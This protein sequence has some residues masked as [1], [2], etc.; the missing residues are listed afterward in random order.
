MYPIESK[1]L[2][3]YKQNYRQVATITMETDTET[4]TITEADIK[5]GGLIFNR[6]SASGERIELGSVIAGELTLKLNNIDGKFNSVQFEGAELYVTIGIKKWDAHAWELPVL[7]TMPLGYFTVDRTPRMLETIEITALDRMVQFDKYVD[8]T[9]ITLPTT[10][11][12]LISHCATACNVPLN[13]VISELP[14]Y[15]Y[16]IKSL[17]DSAELTYRQLVSW[18]AGITGNCAYIDREGRLC[19]GWYEEKD[20]TLTPAE[21]YNSDLLE[22][23]ITITGVAYDMETETYVVGDTAYALDL[24]DNELLTHDY[25]SVLGNL[26]SLIGLSYTPFSANTIPL[27]QLD[28]FDKITFIDKNGNEVSTIITDTTFTLN[29]STALAGKG[30]TEM[31][32]SWAS[33]NPLTNRERVIVEKIMRVQNKELNTRVQSVLE[34]NELIANSLGLFVTDVPQEDGSK[35]RYLHDREQLENSINIFTFTANGIA[36]TN[37]GWNDG[38]PTWQ[39][40]VTSAGDALFRF[41]SAQGIEV[42]SPSNDFNIQIMP[43]SFQVLYR[44]MTVTQIYRDLMTIPRAN[45]TEYSQFGRVRLIPYSHYD[46]ELGEDVELGANLIFVD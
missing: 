43:D 44:A 15:D 5:E 41:L 39:Y 3:L 27:P 19:F 38:S 32:N 22:N 46:S 30:E 17:P 35:I 14:N 7:Y 34:F 20:F 24:T 28:T 9:M 25:N 12:S 40:G 45:F 8:K 31:Q 6:Y 26:S 29:G 33:A 21:R 42:S 16:E 10:I 11:G 36:W 13:I 2:E 1:A 23:A 18:C 37:Q 4:I